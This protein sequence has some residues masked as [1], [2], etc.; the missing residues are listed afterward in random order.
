M[1]TFNCV[2]FEN[3]FKLLSVLFIYFS[4]WLGQR[5]GISKFSKSIKRKTKTVFQ[6]FIGLITF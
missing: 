6:C 5:R 3:S 2:M 1:K 4:A